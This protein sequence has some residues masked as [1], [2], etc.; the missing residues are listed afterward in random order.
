MAPTHWAQLG[1]PI[2]LD[3]P[4]RRARWTPYKT[5][6]S[7]SGHGLRP[8]RRGDKP[9]TPAPPLEISLR[10]RESAARSQPWLRRLPPSRP[11]AAPSPIAPNTPG[12]PCGGRAAGRAVPAGAAA[13]EMTLRWEGRAAFPGLGHPLVQFS[14]RPR[15]PRLPRGPWAAGGSPAA[16]AQPGA[17]TSSPRPLPPAPPYKLG[18]SRGRDGVKIS[19]PRLLQRRHRFRTAGVEPASW[20]RLRGFGL[21]TRPAASGRGRP[22]FAASLPGW[23]LVPKLPALS[24]TVMVPPVFG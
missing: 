14:S 9:Q 11:L 8:G 7:A 24:T 16:S 15:E 21:P 10:R 4:Q 19:G 13:A 18:P 17:P 1:P 12:L 6:R 3:R 23:A 2:L 5:G 22:R 20:G